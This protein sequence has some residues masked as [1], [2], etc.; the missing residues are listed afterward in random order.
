MPCAPN[1]PLPL[2]TSVRELFRPLAPYLD[3]PGVTEI[4][5]NRPGEVFVEAGPHWTRFEAPELTL[6]RCWSMATAIAS[7]ANQRVDSMAPL[8]GAQ[9]P[10]LQRIQIAVPPAVEEHTVAMTIR[11]PDAQVRSFDEYEAQGF[12]SRFMWPQ[13]SKLGNRSQDLDQVQLRLINCLQAGALADFLR[14]AVRHKLNIAFVGDTGSGKTSLMKAACQYIPAEERLITIEDVRELFL[15]K[16]ANRV[17]MLYSRPT[18]GMASVSPADL[19]ATNMRMKPD[20]VLLAELRGGEAFD[21]LKLLTTGHSGSLTSF[22][23]ES[24]ALAVERY[25]LM[26]KEH[27]QAAIYDAEALRRL[28]GLTIDVIVHIKVDLQYAEDGQP[29][30]K[31]RYVAEVSYDPVA[32][33]NHRFGAASLLH[34][35]GL[36]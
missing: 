17:H 28:V 3:I 23:A 2:D 26:C 29:L 32:K 4:A 18:Q 15:P 24:C 9:L 10:G 19:I 12:F 36:P 6:E 16:H 31:E 33:L 11:I 25:I 20:R 14:I 13:P 30:R 1:K 7:Y 8:L 21:F 22:H 34:T 35:R 5:V 27:S